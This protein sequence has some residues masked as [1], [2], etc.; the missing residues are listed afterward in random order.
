MISS[1]TPLA[2]GPLGFELGQKDDAGGKLARRRKFSVKLL[3][4]NAREEFVRQRRENAGP[5]AG[6]RL[7]AAGAAMIHVAEHFLGVDQN[8]VAAL[9][10]DVGNKAHAARVVFEG[11][12]VKTLR[13]GSEVNRSSMFKFSAMTNFPELSRDGDLR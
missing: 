10:F 6:V 1:T 2:V 7:A 4:S 9:A 11:R 3:A 12:I 5:V 13:G 8:L